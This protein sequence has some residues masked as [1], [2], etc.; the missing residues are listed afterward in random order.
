MAVVCKEEDVRRLE[1]NKECFILDLDL[2]SPYL[3]KNSLDN[4]TSDISIVYEKCQVNTTLSLYKT[5]HFITTIA[6]N[7][8][9]Y[10]EERKITTLLVIIR[11]F[12]MSSLDD[13]Y[14]STSYVYRGRSLWRPQVPLQIIVH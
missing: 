11:S 8:T 6:I 4:D 12:I 7:T 3:K 5:S 1:E 2:D 10:M 9:C 14:I 13:N